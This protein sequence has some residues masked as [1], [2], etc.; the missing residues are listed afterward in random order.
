[1]W[2]YNEYGEMVWVNNDHEYTM[3]VGS[4]YSNFSF[5]EESCIVDNTAWDGWA[6]AFGLAPKKKCIFD[7]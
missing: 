2:R 6:E 7:E 5:Y 3:T 4:T 1:M